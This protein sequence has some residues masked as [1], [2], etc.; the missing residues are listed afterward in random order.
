MKKLL[1]KL[2]PESVILQYH[3]GL[4]WFAAFVYGFPARQLIVIGVT[5][6]KG[7]TTTANFIWSS[8]T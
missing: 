1:R 4:A 5:G 6:T 8:I 3:R 2:I 7:K